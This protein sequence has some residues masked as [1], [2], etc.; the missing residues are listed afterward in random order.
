LTVFHKDGA[1]EAALD[2]LPHHVIGHAVVLEPV[3]YA[4]V[5]RVLRRKAGVLEQ[6]G[7]L[8]RFDDAPAVCDVAKFSDG[9]FWVPRIGNKLFVST[10][11]GKDGERDQGE[12]CKGSLSYGEDYTIF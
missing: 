6:I 7:Q 9:Y 11:S 10:S 3:R 8:F 1:P 5:Y 2:Q 12:D 4:Y